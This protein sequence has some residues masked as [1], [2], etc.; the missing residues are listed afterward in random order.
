MTT[1][2]ILTRIA[3]LKAEITR[4]ENGNFNDEEFR[5]EYAEALDGTYPN[6]TVGGLNLTHS[7]ILINCDPI[8]FRVSL[9][10]YF[11]NELADRQYELTLKRKRTSKSRSQITIFW[12]EL[13]APINQLS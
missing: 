6:Y 12:G 7:E 5:K 8:Y 9:S 11:N 1:E 4:L 3:K 13:F 10:E 2:V